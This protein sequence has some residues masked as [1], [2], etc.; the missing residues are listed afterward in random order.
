MK[1]ALFFTRGVSLEQW[2]VSGLFD[3]EKLIYERHIADGTLSQVHW[4]TYGHRDAA[5]AERLYTDE[6]LDPKIIVWPMPKCFALPKVGSWLYSFLL[7]LVHRHVIAEVDILK[8]NQMSGSWAAVIAKI[9]YRKKLV[10]RTGYTWSMFAFRINPK[11]FKRVIIRIIERIAYLFSDEIIV[12]SCND[13]EYLKKNYTFKKNIVVIPNYIDTDVFKPLNMQKVVNSICFI[14][15]LNK[16]K[17]LFSLLEAMVGLPYKLTIIGSGDN[18]ESLEKYA[19]EKGIKVVFL[20]NIPNSELPEILNQ[21]EVFILPSFYEGTPK[22]L[23]EAMACGLSCIGSNVEGIREVIKH[24]ENGYLC[25]TDA[26]SIRQAILEVLEDRTLQENIGQN[27]RRTILDDFSLE[28]CLEKE[29]A[30]YE[31]L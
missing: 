3:R 15:R 13:T 17:N 18:K 8:T 7:P 6:K 5:V 4:F 21:N 23:L 11:G 22:A 28:K 14:G 12:S 1:L 29:I 20:N 19:K 16:Q 30:L 24:K 2:V 31:L 25:E 27:A 26:E 10:V 9:L